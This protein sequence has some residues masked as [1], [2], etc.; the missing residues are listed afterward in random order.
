MKDEK[1][2]VEKKDIIKVTEIEDFVKQG[3]A[4]F[5]QDEIYNYS[6]PDSVIYIS[7]IIDKIR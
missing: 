6:R 1:E 5:T 4:I 2:V 3:K 7:F